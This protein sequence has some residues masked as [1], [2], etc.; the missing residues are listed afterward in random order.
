MAGFDT[1]R[2][3]E[4][5]DQGL[6][7]V[8]RRRVR[9]LSVCSAMLGA[10]AMI[11][12][13]Q[14]ASGSLSETPHLLQ[15]TPMAGKD[16][17][18]LDNLVNIMQGSIGSRVQRPSF[19]MPFHPIGGQQFGF[20]QSQHVTQGVTRQSISQA[21]KKASVEVPSDDAADE[22]QM[23]PEILG[24]QNSLLAGTP[25]EPCSNDGHCSQLPESGVHRVCVEQSPDFDTGLQMSEKDLMK[26]LQKHKVVELRSQ[27]EARGL[28]TDGKKVMLVERLAASLS[29]KIVGRTCIDAWTYAAEV[30]K[31]PVE[32]GG[33][34]LKCKR[35]SSELRNFYKAEMEHPA[36]NFD[37]A[38]W[39]T[40]KHALD[41]IEQVCGPAPA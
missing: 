11:V 33:L 28:P 38:V 37:I 4:L 39:Y 29:M 22:N 31:D 34:M 30:V 5:E 17:S 14:M 40:A 6:D 3:V 1:H 23:P 19:R 10:S 2:Y 35:T 27:L 41:K 15:D 25:L 24:E 32:V 36:A 20:H 18:E 21:K 13:C 16:Q 26:K 7:E 9:V 12:A 8:S